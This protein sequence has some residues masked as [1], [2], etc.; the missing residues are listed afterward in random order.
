M[1]SPRIDPDNPSGSQAG[2]LGVA[3]PGRERQ[4][5]GFVVST[6]A[7][8]T[9]QTVKAIVTLPVK[10]STSAGPPSV[11]SSATRTGPMSVVGAG[12]VAGEMASHHAIPLAD[13]FFSLLLLL[14]GLNLFLGLFNFLPLPP[15]TAARSPRPLGGSQRDRQAAPGPTPGASTSPSCCRSPTWWPV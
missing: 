5:L 7:D 8:G 10:L 1:V 2:F 4:S 15:S 6:M 14:A 12:R 13:R 3:P 11:S 9:G